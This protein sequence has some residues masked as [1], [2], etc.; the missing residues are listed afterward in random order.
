MVKVK[1]YRNYFG[2]VSFIQIKNFDC[3]PE[4]IR[5]VVSV[6]NPQ[7]LLIS[8]LTLDLGSDFT[9]LILRSENKYKVILPTENVITSE[10]VIVTERHNFLSALDLLVESEPRDI[11]LYKMNEI[12]FND[13]LFHKK[14]QNA[15]PDKLVDAGIVDYAVSVVLEESLVIVSIN[16]N[17]VDAKK[18]VSEIKMIFDL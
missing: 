16:S 4:N 8:V 15:N 13:I 7:F 9:K 17:N 5:R 11:T 10:T 12:D 18:V 3:T 2:K 6:F 1:F 14:F